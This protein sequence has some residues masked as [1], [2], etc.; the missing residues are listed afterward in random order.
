MRPTLA[1][2]RDLAIHGD[3]SAGDRAENVPFG[4]AARKVS[5]V[6]EPGRRTVGTPT[7]TKTAKSLT[8]D[9]TMQVATA[10]L[11]ALGKLAATAR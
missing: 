7:T 4:G 6:E 8:H 11:H 5:T 1:A 10:P 9:I 2:Q 3:L